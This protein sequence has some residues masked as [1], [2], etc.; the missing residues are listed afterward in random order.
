[1]LHSVRTPAHEVLSP[2]TDRHSGGAARARCYEAR[3]ERNL[4]LGI[5]GLPGPPCIEPDAR[6]API[7]PL[8]ATRDHLSLYFHLA[9]RIPSGPFSA[10][11]SSA[12]IP[13]GESFSTPWRH[14]GDGPSHG[15]D[16][17]V[18]LNNDGPAGVRIVWEPAV[19]PEDRRAVPPAVRRKKPP[20]FRMRSALPIA[21][22]V[23][24]AALLGALVGP[25]LFP[26]QPP[27]GP[28]ATSP[29][30]R[31]PVPSN[32]PEDQVAVPP[33]SEF[34]LEPSGC[35][36]GCT[37][38]KPGC[39]IKG[40]ITYDHIYHLPGQLFY[41]RTKISPER[42]ERWFCTEEEARANG[43]RKSMM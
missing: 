26:H 10:V 17:A 20:T 41:K 1:M 16:V 32:P 5:P 33:P 38:H 39:D 2:K 23:G 8:D 3:G 34:S 7:V 29:A 25:R 15:G 42:G 14:P 36:K 28:P 9:N 19:G 35:P 27:D 12:G 18:S 13:L 6:A 30:P 22:I 43:W 24:V 31:P 21:A 4:A 40:N 11:G 37:K